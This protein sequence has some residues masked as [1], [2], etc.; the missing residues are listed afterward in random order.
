M[1]T[2]IFSQ[3][4]EHLYTRK[5]GLTGSQLISHFVKFTLY[6]YINWK[7]WWSFNEKY[8]VPFMGAKMC[9]ESLSGREFN[10]ELQ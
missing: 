2:F 6:N 5:T 3:D 8:G 10:K 4:F 7:N 1:E 9:L